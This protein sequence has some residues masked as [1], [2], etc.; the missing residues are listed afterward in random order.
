ML[1]AQSS[2]TKTLILCGSCWQSTCYHCFY[3]FATIINSLSS[4]IINMEFR[5]KKAVVAVCH[6]SIWSVEMAIADFFLLPEHYQPSGRVA[7]SCM[8]LKLAHT[9]DKELWGKRSVVHCWIWIL[10]WC[11]TMKINQCCAERQVLSDCHYWRWCYHLIIQLFG[12]ISYCY[13]N[14]LTSM[15]WDFCYSP[16]PF[17]TLANICNCNS[18]NI[19]L[20]N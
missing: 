8:T 11:T 15:Q 12:G 1:S 2:H 17:H 10:Q 14:K 7:L 6:Q 13:S 4:S 9:V 20:I 18:R 3:Y 5:Y 19:L 16:L